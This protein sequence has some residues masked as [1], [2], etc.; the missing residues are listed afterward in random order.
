M[1]QTSVQYERAFMYICIIMIMN[2]SYQLYVY[3]D[4]HHYN[5]STFNAHLVSVWRGSTSKSKSLVDWRRRLLNIRI[6]TF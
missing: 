2:S 6:L 4:K 3:W 1:V 5:T